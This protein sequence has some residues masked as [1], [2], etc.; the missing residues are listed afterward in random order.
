[1]QFNV[2][3]FIDIED[4]I[5]GPLALKQFLYLVGGAG[6]LF[7]LWSLLTLGFF[8]VIAIPI[9]ILCILLAFY[10][11]NGRPFINFLGSGIVYLSK[12]RL[13]LWKKK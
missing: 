6:V 4:K 3:Q 11:V 10:K 2:P 8:I 13:Y 7:L 12:P 5:I 1:M 9:G